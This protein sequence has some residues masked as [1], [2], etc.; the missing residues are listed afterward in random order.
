MIKCIVLLEKTENGQSRE[1]GN[2]RHTKQKTKTSKAKHTTQHVLD[3]TIR[4]LRLDHDR[5]TPG[6]K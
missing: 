3:T 2:I 4:K 5:R 6:S 1:T